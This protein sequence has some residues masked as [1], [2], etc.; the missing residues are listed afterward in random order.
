MKRVAALVC[1]GGVLVG[2]GC[3]TS[4]AKTIDFCNE[5]KSDVARLGAAPDVRDLDAQVAA[6][7]RLQ[8][9]APD[10]IKPD[11]ETVLTATK[12]MKSNPAAVVTVIAGK[13]YRDAAGHVVAFLKEH[14]GIS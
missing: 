12:A 3:T 2:S 6:L 7:S 11:V 10:E 4:E 14:C 5:A 9:K 13:K 8:A 1:A